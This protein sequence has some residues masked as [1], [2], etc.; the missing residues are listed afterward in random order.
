MYI[1]ISLQ[2]NQ[3]ERIAC[4]LNSKQYSNLFIKSLDLTYSYLLNQTIGQLYNNL[5]NHGSMYIYMYIYN[6]YL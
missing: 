6:V 2:V 1:L 4:P 3:R 5:L